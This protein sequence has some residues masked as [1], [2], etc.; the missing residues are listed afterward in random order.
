MEALRLAGREGSSASEARSLPRRASDA[1]PPP[2]AGLRHY[3]CQG[4]LWSAL[5]SHRWLR[6][7]YHKRSQKVGRV[8]RTP[9]AIVGLAK[10]HVRPLRPKFRDDPFRLG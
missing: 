4:F 10:P 3:S 8:I 2:N 7:W 5:A 6:G 1:V 9:V